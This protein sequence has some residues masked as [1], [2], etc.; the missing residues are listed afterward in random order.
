[1]ISMEESAKTDQILA[2]YKRIGLEIFECGNYI[3][4]SSAANNE[5]H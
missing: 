1:M 2:M 5:R 4:S 3:T